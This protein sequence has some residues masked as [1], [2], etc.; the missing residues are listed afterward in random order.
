MELHAVEVSRLVHHRRDGRRVVAR[1]N[2]E[3]RRQRGDLVAVAHPDVEQAM[4]RVVGT[5]LDALQQSAVP[6]RANLGVSEFA[7]IAA[8]DRP[9]ELRRPGL[10]AVLTMRR[11]EKYRRVTQNAAACSAALTKKVVPMRKSLGGN[12]LICA[13]IGVP[14]NGA[15]TN[16][17]LL[18]E[19]KAPMVTPCSRGSTALETIPCSAGPT[20]KDRKLARMI[21]YIIHP[22]GARP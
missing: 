8:C 13:R 14:I 1:H 10:H 3:P 6:A 22:C 16:M 12:R 21:A 19:L 7:R 15:T 18:I 20:A 5:V 9:A 2:A 11:G 4:A 17:M